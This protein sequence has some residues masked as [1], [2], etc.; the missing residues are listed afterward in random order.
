MRRI[1]LISVVALAF[2]VNS[3]AQTT[4]A[5]ITGIVT[6]A[7]G[8]VV[9]GAQVTATQ[10]SSN[11]KYTAKSNDVGYYTL[12]QL[13]QGE[14]SMRVEA[15]GFNSSVIK[16]ILLTAQE[17]RRVDVRLEVGAVATT[18]EVVGG[19]TPIETESA[20]ISDTKLASQ[21][22]NLPLNTR[23]LWNFVGQNPGIVS[24]ASG[25]ATRRF[26]GSRNNQS[27][28]SVDG[29]TVSNGRDGTQITPLVNYV[30]SFQEVRVDMGNNTAEFGSLGQVTVVSKS[31]SNDLHGAGFDYYTTPVFLARNPFSLTKSG[32][33]QHQPGF[34][35]GGPMYFPKLYNGKNRTFFFFSMET[36]RGGQAKDILNPTVPAANWRQGNFANLLPSTVVKDPMGGNAPFAGNI[37][38]TTRLNAVSLK[39]QEKFYPLPNF[40]DPNIFAS[41]NYR[42]T[43]PRPYD[44][45][46][47]WT[48]RLDHRFSETAFVFGRFTWAKQYTRPLDNNL[49]TIGRIWNQRENQGANISF[50]YTIKSSLINEIRWGVAYN[51]QPRHGAQNGLQLVKELGLLGLA[52]NLPDIAGI[53]QLGWTGIGI[54]PLTQQVWRHPGFKNKF[55][56]VQE[57]LNW[58]HGR[59][60]VKAGFM[61]NRVYYADGSAP[62]NLFG[63]V[64]FSNR[65]TGHPYGDFLLGIPTTYARA[66]PNV[67]AQELRSGYD[68]F[69]ADQFKITP[70]L[71]LDMGVRYEY[72]P[73][74]RNVD[75]YS[76]TFDIGSGK[77]IVPD[78]SLNK[79]SPLMP[80][81]YVGIEVGSKLGLPSNLAPTDRNNFAPR[82]GLAWRPFGPNTVFR[83]GY[84][85]YYDIVPTTAQ[86]GGIPFI[87]AE[88]TQT[89]STT[90]PEVIFPRVYTASVTA[91]P[92]TVSL[93]TARNPNLV[94]PY[95]MQYN[96]TIE[97]LVGSNAFRLSY[98]GTNTRKGEYRYN[99]NQPLSG[100]GLF[101]TKPRMFPTYPAVNYQTNGA[102]HQYNAMTAE[103]KRRAASG[104]TYQL[105]YTLARDIGDAERNDLIENAYDR[106]RDRGVWIDIPA[107]RVNGSLIWDLPV[108]KGKKV[109]A[110]AGRGL[111]LLAGGWSMSAIYSTRSGRFLTPTW[112]GPDPTGTA[113]TSSASIPT[114]TLRPNILRDPNLPSSQQAVNRWFDVDA[115][116]APGAY[117]GSSSIGVI[118]GPKM[119]VWDF[120]IFKAFPIGERATVRWELTAVNLLNHP[121]YN[122]PSI[123]ISAAAT[124]GVIGGVGGNSTVSGASAPLD[125]AGPRSL[126][127][128]LRIEF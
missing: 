48:T 109:L 21:I 88:P 43:V 78:E 111:N 44:P 16:S 7:Q 83:A 77:I 52:P 5:T 24:A 115:F 50:T 95:S 70:S 97:H 36:A 126:R 122:D 14:Y 55:N 98:I 57:Q 69:V 26:S 119:T 23:S 104:L 12:G 117:F 42:A 4:F 128:G 54:Q 15:P 59:H 9:A 76:S 10:L 118:K 11:Y 80:L 62:T 35:I 3:F 41:Q 79:V 25:T 94:I 121:N 74:A 99:I 108:G 38:P 28:A 8:A 123:S 89:N 1:L 113:Y 107:H 82:I 114:V 124:R 103:V 49:P 75:G 110:N 116:A 53:P 102:G 34:T 96:V 67:V 6:D 2:H 120:G 18:V 13:L 31:G 17:L 39:L 30:E 71:T 100:P 56:Q 84:G 87:I 47:Y 93:P 90:A 58:Y 127:M 125:P 85:I 105:S 37:V 63:N 81:K 20:R 60:S 22:K 51:D 45:S 32:N 92:S 72:H 33:V 29:I 64:T 65:F 86:S 68:W 40:G 66:F 101:G 19:A 61:F 106:A 27:D 73:V 91:G 46:T 112:S